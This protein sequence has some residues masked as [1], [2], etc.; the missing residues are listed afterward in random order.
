MSPRHVTDEPLRVA[1]AL[2]G[3]ELASPTRRA[4]A[5][6][7]DWAVLVLP[8]VAVALAAAMLSLRASDPRGYRALVDLWTGGNQ[9]PEA[10]HAT[11]RDI[12]PLLVHAGAP[13]LPPAI[14]SA[15]EV[16]DLD[17]AA[18]LLADTDF[19]FSLSLDPHA[20][21]VAPARGVRVEIGHFIPKML[22]AAALY[23]V[24]ALYFTLLT[25]GCRGATLG[26]RLLGIR[27]VRL[28][29]H[30]L[31]LM[32]SFERFVGY[33]HIPGSLGIGLLDLWHDPN[34]RM[35]HDR[36]VHTA[37]LRVLPRRRR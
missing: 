33:L 25:R 37:V 4:L 20:G 14:A 8:S 32:E 11:L 35:A 31:S 5:L 28:D 7:V 23:G 12:A 1:E 18:V 3:A 27:V 16:G 30:R 6:G 13:G 2:R 17:R 9:T 24:A 22:R 15:V 26:K 10:Q 21:K 19:M 34:R 29:G 36:T